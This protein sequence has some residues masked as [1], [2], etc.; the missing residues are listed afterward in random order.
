[1]YGI[2]LQVEVC[3]SNNTAG[4]FVAICGYKG[5]L[6]IMGVYMAWETRHIKVQLL[7]DSQ[8]IGICVYCAFFT[9]IIVI[10]SNFFSNYT[11][12]TYLAT[13][14]TILTSTTITL[15]LLFLPKLKAVIRKV[16]V[17]DP[18]MQS[19]G[20]KIECNTRRLVS[21][22][23][24]ELT[25]RME[26][27]NKVYRS[28]LE[29]L[30]REI[31]RLEELL[32]QYPSSSIESNLSGPFIVSNSIFLSPPKNYQRSSCPVF[33]TTPQGISERKLNENILDKLKK[34]V[35]SIPSMWLNSA[36]TFAKNNE[37][38]AA[39]VLKE[40]PLSNPDVYKYSLLDVNFE[41][42]KANSENN[43]SWK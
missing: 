42:V 11:T 9:A 24:K 15:F 38:T 28:E 30:D 29:A 5:F 39:D 1:M 7:N 19:M 35:G 22:D 40:K 33:Q 31:S 23:P 4:W 32:S 25:Y 14:F 12:L 10:L 8:Y 16:D 36:E 34:F 37:Q 26:V 17:E 2:E 43:I 18:L 20:L 6:L 41:C 3:R 27:Q 21:D 13:T